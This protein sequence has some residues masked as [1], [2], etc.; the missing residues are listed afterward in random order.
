MKEVNDPRQFPTYSKENLL[1]QGLFLFLS[2]ES[3]RNALNNRAQ[4]GDCYKNNFSSLFG[5]MNWAHFDTV[6][7]FLRMSN[8]ED[9]E[10]VKTKMIKSLIEKKRIISFYGR[11]PV[12]IDAT[13]VTTYD[14]DPEGNLLHRNSGTGKKTYLNIML[15]AKIVT[16]EGLCLSIA[17]EPLSNTEAE[18]YQKQ[19]CELKAFKRITEKIK[20]F[21]PRLPVCLLLDG[22]YA[23]N[24]VFDICREYEWKYIVSLKDG[25]LANLQRTIADTEEAKR[26]RFERPVIKKNKSANDDDSAYYQCIE[27]LSHKG[28]LFNWIE[29]IWP[30][31]VKNKNGKEATPTHF[32]F[33]TNL[34]LHNDASQ[35]P[36]IIVKMVQA[37]RLRWKIENEGFNTQKNHGYH[38]H[39]KFSRHSVKT[40]HVYYILLQIAHL[41]NQLVMHSKEI[42][43]LMKKHPKL[44]IRY[45]WEKLRSILENNALSYQRL[46]QNKRNSQIRLE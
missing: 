26:I 35:K 10:K 16:P 15:E 19:D 30:P 39:H 44:T 17:S 7:D 46:E 24:T 1:C 5:G 32:V 14:E 20:Q 3:S 42:V 33:L 36:G 8:M 43:V 25:S 13:G 2:Q 28:H 45:L 27:N 29:C 18:S 6:D 38:L 23:N 41:I 21:F 12:V 37:G 40:L 4:H 22:L 31:L 34:P 9:V 11:Y